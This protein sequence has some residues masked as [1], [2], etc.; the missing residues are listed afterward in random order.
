MGAA[1]GRK[2]RIEKH[3]LEEARRTSPIL[4]SGQLVP[5]ESPD[6]LL[7]R[8]NGPL[9]IEVTELSREEPRAEAARL[10]KIPE[11][12]KALYGR[13]TGSE[14]INVSLAFSRRAGELTVKQLRNLLAKFV[15]ERRKVEGS[16]H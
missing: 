14:P 8:D 9:G 11:Q 12:A 1:D 13:E 15:Y 5:Y 2:K 6:F 4:P 7:H 3:Y 16:A 10:A